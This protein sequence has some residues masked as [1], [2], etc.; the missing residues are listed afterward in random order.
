MQEVYS[1]SSSSKGNANQS[2]IHKIDTKTVSEEKRHNGEEF[3]KLVTLLPEAQLKKVR[4]FINGLDGSSNVVE[5]VLGVGRDIEIRW[6]VLLEGGL[7]KAAIAN[8]PISR[9]HI[10][11]I[12]CDRIGE[13]RFNQQDRAGIDGTLHRISV[14]RNENGDPVAVNMRVGRSSRMLASVI[15]DII[16]DASSFLLLGPPGVGKTTLL[17]ACAGDLSSDQVVVIV[18]PSG[19]IAG[20]GD[21]C[22]PA[23]GEAWKDFAYFAQQVDRSEA[24]RLAMGRALENMGPQVIVVDEIGT[25]GEAR[26]ARTIAGCNLL[27]LRMGGPCVISSPIPSSEISSAASNR[28]PLAMTTSDTCQKEGRTSLSGAASPCSRG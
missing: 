21:T 24:R 27:Q 15:E 3:E 1:S 17:R 5:I 6:R 19:E 14:T 13:D 12:V 7:R 2:E 11:E 25:L 4:E 26:A 23:V 9:E 8:T 22:H 18:D 10:E 16:Q 28:Q 20:S